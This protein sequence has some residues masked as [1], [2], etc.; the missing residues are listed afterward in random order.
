MA[1]QHPSQ[2]KEGS[3]ARL[4]RLILLFLLRYIIHVYDARHRPSLSARSCPPP[5]RRHEREHEHR[6]RIGYLSVSPQS[7]PPPARRPSLPSSPL[8]PH[9]DVSITRFRRSHSRS[10]GR[11]LFR[12]I[13]ATP[14]AL[15]KQNLSSFVCIFLS[16]SLSLLLSSV[17]S[18]VAAARSNS[19]VACV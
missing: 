10:F 3:F 2:A 17:V 18:V 12:F 7:P 9:L 4:L 19:L 8:F 16:I 13:F 11:S 14:N 5:P 6:F 1:R 15:E